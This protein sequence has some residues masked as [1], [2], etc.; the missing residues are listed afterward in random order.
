MNG[1]QRACDAFADMDKEVYE[2][3]K[4]LANASLEPSDMAREAKDNSVLLYT[5]AS[6]FVYDYEEKMKQTEQQAI[7][8]GNPVQM[9]AGDINF[10][11]NIS[12]DTLDGSAEGLTD[13][14][15]AMSQRGSLVK[16]EVL[17]QVKGVMY[18]MVNRSRN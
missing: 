17:E 14:V 2:L 12:N 1:M 16:S 15:V 7:G 10:I 5:L 8:V 4:R 11:P 13:I 18:G 3:A 6:M 9:Y